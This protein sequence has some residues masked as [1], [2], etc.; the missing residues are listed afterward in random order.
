M[1]PK[2][3]LRHILVL[4][5]LLKHACRSPGIRWGCNWEKYFYINLHW[6]KSSPNETNRPISTKLDANCM[7]EIQVYLNK[8]PSPHQRG[9]N[10]KNANIG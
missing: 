5:L 1:C 4:R 2:I 7:K 10:H 6:K 8:W 3:Y 9:D